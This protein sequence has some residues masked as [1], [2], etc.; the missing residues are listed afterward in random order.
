MKPK[1]V[2]HPSFRQ[3]THSSKKMFLSGGYCRPAIVIVD[4][5]QAAINTFQVA[6]PPLPG[7]SVFSTSASAS[8]KSYNDLDC[9]GATLKIRS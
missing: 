9:K 3:G 4:F 8:T 1:N 2:G 7:L 6:F 5:E